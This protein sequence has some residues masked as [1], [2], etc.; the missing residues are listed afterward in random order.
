[1]SE[2]Y[3]NILLESLKKKNDVLDEIIQISKR[4]GEI[5]AAKVVSYEEF[6]R[7]VD[8]KDVCIEQLDKLDEG[9]ET[10]Y[11]RVKQELDDNR[12]QHA[13]WIKECQELIARITDKSVEIQAMEARNKQAVEEN[14]R[15]ERKGY[16]QGKRSVE[17]AHSYYRSMNRTGVVPPHF[18]DQKK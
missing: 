18:M 12:A 15:R 11:Q 4:Q 7:C 10:L 5:L 9:F 3:L 2:Q 8:D 6:D 14:F 16:N 17:I 13:A 1:M